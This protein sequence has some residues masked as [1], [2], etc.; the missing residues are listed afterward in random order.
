MNVSAASSDRLSAPGR[1]ADR[2]AWSAL[3]SLVIAAAALV[4]MLNRPGV[5]RLNPL[6]LYGSFIAPSAGAITLSSASL[7]LARRARAGTWLPATALRLSL[8]FAVVVALGALAVVLMLWRIA[9]ALSS[10]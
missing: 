7:Y 6:F 3:A 8:G 1:W 5:P 9:E 2:L 4:W 10:F